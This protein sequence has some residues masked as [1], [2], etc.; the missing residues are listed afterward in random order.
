M[1]PV[2]WF[3][4]CWS[5]RRLCWSSNCFRDAVRICRKIPR[6][7]YW[8]LVCVFFLWGDEK[9]ADLINRRVFHLNLFAFK[10]KRH[11]AR[12]PLT[13]WCWGRESNPHAPKDTGFSYQLRFSPPACW[14]FVVWTLSSPFTISTAVRRKPLS[15]Y[16]FPKITMLFRLS[17]VL[18][19]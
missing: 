14:Q 16:T 2:D 5:S 11:P 9:C 4:C 1:S 3:I 18:P 17:S 12:T 15:L 6:T 8:N 19:F 7:A 10:R 13:F